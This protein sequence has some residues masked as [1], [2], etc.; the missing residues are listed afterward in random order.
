[1]A[2]SRDVLFILAGYQSYESVCQCDEMAPFSITI[3]IT[4][5]MPLW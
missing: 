4:A 2:G 3:F 5:K 1:M